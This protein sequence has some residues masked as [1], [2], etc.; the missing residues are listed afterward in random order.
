VD[1]AGNLESP[2]PATLVAIDA[3]S[4]AVT[5][6]SPEPRDY[7]HSDS[8]ML[9]FSAADSTSGVQSVSAALDGAIVQNSQ[10]I[11][12]LTQTLGAH[13][14]EVSATDAAG[15]ATVQSVSFRV[16]A[17]IDSLISSVNLY[18]LQG[19]IDVAKQ[20][21]LLDKLN[22]ARAALSRGNT[23]AASGSLRDFRD[24]CSAQSGRGIA[25]DAAA[26]LTA[27]ADYVL[28]TL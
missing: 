7:Q 17:T 14:L 26:V 25:I 13:T 15:N 21:G 28:R 19:K 18:A 22:D 9:S 2:L 8:V 27:D 24:Q 11:L 6:A 16:V 4:P 12:L 5:I 3:L 1:R 10:S 23:S 20:R